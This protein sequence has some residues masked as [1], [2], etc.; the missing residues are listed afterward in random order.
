[1]T[2]VSPD[3]ELV[4]A[5]AAQGSEAAFRALVE[6]HVHLVYATALRQTGSGA[7]AE[8]ITQNVFISLARKAPRLAGVETLAGWLYRATVLETKARVRSELRR[9]QREQTASEVITLQHEGASPFAALLPLLDE[10]LRDLRESDR[11]ALVL[12][13]LEERS[14]REVGD[15]LGVDEDAARKR[16]ARALERLGNFFRQRGFAVPAGGGGAALLSSATQAAPPTLAACAGN[17][18]LAAGAGSGFNP[19]LFHLMTLTKTQMAAICALAVAAPLLL[20]HRAQATAAREQAAVNAQLAA[21]AQRASAAD[22]QLDQA[23]QAAARAETEALNAKLHLDSIGTQLANR[24]ARPAYHWDDT[25]PSLRLPK[26]SLRQTQLC[27][28]ANRRGQLTDQIKEALQMTGAES[29]QTQAA[30]T[31]F[32]STYNAF[33]ARD[34]RAVPPNDDELQGHTPDQTR[35]FDVPYIGSNQMNQL[36][37]DFFG[38]VASLLGDQRG[39][40]FTNALNFWM[41]VTED[42]HGISSGMA[43]FNAS[44]RA[45]FYQ[46]KPGDKSITYGVDLYYGMSQSPGSRM[47]AE[48]PA[49]DVP[50]IF[51]PSLQDWIAQLS[52]PPAA[53][54]SSAP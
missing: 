44:Y 35:V 11:L 14:L 27:A 17:A 7:L 43:V 48:I 33:E 16:V 20:Q 25:S 10:A 41:P 28:A 30:V 2:A 8:D 26:K 5:Y 18:A 49:D 6:R 47:T 53:D 21:A 31:R 50:E 42:F 22:A 51:Q 12:R 24:A 34:L 45:R 38:Q 13:F 32:L 54:P 9:R 36:R 3:S 40:L 4:Q 52:T 1:M 19:V 15:I 23:R 29:G 39:E 37:Q 46:P